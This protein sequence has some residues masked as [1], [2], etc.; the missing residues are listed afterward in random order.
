M[1]NVIKRTSLLIT[2]FILLLFSVIRCYSGISDQ[3]TGKGYFSFLQTVAARSTTAPWLIEGSLL[4]RSEGSWNPTSWVSCYGSVRSRLVYGDFVELVPGYSKHLSVSNGFF[5]LATRWN[6]GKSWVLHSEIDRLYAEFYREKWL[7]RLGRHRI[8]WGMNLVWNPNDLFNSYSLFDVEYIERPGT[9]A[10]LLEYYPSATSSLQLVYKIGDNPDSLTIAALARV[11][12][13]G[14]DLQVLGGIT[15]TDLVT[16]GGWSG[17]IGGGGFRGEASYFH[18]R[19][20]VFDSTGIFTASVSGDYTFPSELYLHTAFLY[21]S[22]GTDKKT[23][24]SSSDLFESFNYSAKQLSH[25]RFGI[26][27]QVTYPITP[28]VYLELQGIVNPSDHSFFIG[29]AIRFSL[30]D[31]AELRIVG[32]LF[33]GA[34]NT[35]FGGIGMLSYASLKWN[36]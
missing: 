28:L 5:D 31:N 36:F 34:D 16:G 32:Q 9:D 11:N 4:N 18:P 8:N 3:F 17:Q 2:W 25:S 35:E 33:E 22:N 10:M 14:Y 24:T 23:R 21:V 27:G 20:H 7:I 29:P 15:G 19:Y 30:S 26:Y 1:M 6:D 12:V 13:R